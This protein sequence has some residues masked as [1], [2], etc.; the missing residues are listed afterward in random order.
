MRL[1]ISLAVI[2]VEIE[3][4]RKGDENVSSAFLFVNFVL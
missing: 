3:S 4:T 1:R 2:F